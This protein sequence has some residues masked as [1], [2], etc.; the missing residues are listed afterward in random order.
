MSSRQRVR[1]EADV[2]GAGVTPPVRQRER[3]GL[4][5]TNEESN[6]S[7]A[8]MAARR[9]WLLLLLDGVARAG[10]PS[11]EA[12]RLHRLA[13]LANCLAAMYDLPAADGKILKYQR[14]PFYPVFQW[15]L[16]RLVAMGLVEVRSLR[17]ELDVFGPWFHAE[18][19]LSSVALPAVEH[20]RRAPG[21]E[22]THRFLVEIATAYA[23]LPEDHREQAALV[24]AT[25]AD[26]LKLE[27][28]VIDYAQWHVRNFS[29][30]TANAFEQYLASGIRLSQ[31]EKLHLYFHY[32]DRAVTRVAV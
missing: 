27:G 20:L 2:N 32:L 11:V 4:G 7:P 22:R 17:H 31:R 28:S 19:A 9:S 6:D 1:S 5:H 3:G 30:G 21:L 8:E 24:D 10:L 29:I 26:P 23:A 16:D 18:Y 25:Y 12:M 14:G 13:F 15:D